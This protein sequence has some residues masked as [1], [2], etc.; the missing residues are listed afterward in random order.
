MMEKRP[1]ICRCEEI[2]KEEIISAIRQG[3]RRLG[4]ITSLAGRNKVGI[5][6]DCWR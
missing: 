4:V 2:T 1:F 3:Q 5:C 6:D